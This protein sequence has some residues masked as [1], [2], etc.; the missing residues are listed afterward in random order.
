MSCARSV[1]SIALPGPARTR[2]C[3]SVQNITC[4][5]PSKTRPS[6][7]VH[8]KKA[9]D[10]LCGKDNPCKSMISY[11]EKLISR[12]R[13]G[14]YERR[15]ARMSVAGSE[16]PPANKQSATSAF[17]PFHVNPRVAR[18][19]PMTPWSFFEPISIQRH[20]CRT[21]RMVQLPAFELQSS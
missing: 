6:D 5:S 21:G 9:F 11:R 3:E 8:V 18:P 19:L 15:R 7:Y 20:R 10:I 4:N 13:R 14:D 17:P 16:I 1:V 2:V 12:G